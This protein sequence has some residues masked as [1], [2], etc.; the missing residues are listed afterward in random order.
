MRMGLRKTDVMGLVKF[1][2]VLLATPAMLLAVVYL[3]GSIPAL[4]GLI[5]VL[6][7]VLYFAGFLSALIGGLLVLVGL[8]VLLLQSRA[9]RKN[10]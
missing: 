7:V 9:R 8:S 1:G 6:V 10:A 3:G 4:A 5:Q 2:L